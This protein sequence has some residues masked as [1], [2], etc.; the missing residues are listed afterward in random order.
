MMSG[1]AKTFFERLSR[2]GNGILRGKQLKVFIHGSDPRDAIDSTENL[3][4]WFCRVEGMTNLG[5]EVV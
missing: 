1:L 5:V 3:V 2:D 4:H